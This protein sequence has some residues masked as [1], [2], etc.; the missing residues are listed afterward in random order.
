MN[1]T[2]CRKIL[3]IFIMVFVVLNSYGQGGIITYNK[4]Y[5]W[6]NIASKMPFLSVEERDRIRLTWGTDENYKGEEYLLTFNNAGSVYKIKEKEEN[7]GYSWGEDEDV[8]IRNFETRTTND[9]RELL[10]KLYLIEEEIP[11]FKWKILNELKEVA[12]YVCMKAETRDTVYD[13][14]I[15][16]WFTDKIQLSGGPEGFGGLPG[17]ILELSYNND[18]IHIVASKVELKDEAIKLPIPKKLKGKKLSYQE[19]NSKKKKHITLVEIHIGNQV[20]N[21]FKVRFQNQGI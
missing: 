16:A 11:R 14:V 2:S 6:V 5:Y 8:F 15:T 17:A 13:I 4:K 12:G 21:G 3:A 10:G 18:D 7:Y 20:L 1:S 9:R 19:Y